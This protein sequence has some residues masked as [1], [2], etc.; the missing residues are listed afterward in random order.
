MIKNSFNI[1]NLTKN[2]AISAIMIA[3]SFILNRYASITTTWFRLGFASTPIVLTSLL[4]GPI[5]G[6]LVGASADLISAF[7][8][9]Q[10][11]Y[12][13]GY[14][15][16]NTLIGVLPYFTSMLIKG[17]KI[18]SST[19][20][21]SLV[22]VICLISVIFVSKYETFKKIELS[23]YI[24]ILIPFFFAL[25]YILLFF[26]YNLFLVKVDKFKPS[27]RDDITY[28]LSDI[29]II[30]LVNHVFISL[31]LLPTWNYIVLGLDF[32]ITSFS[33]AFFHLI[34]S[35]IKSTLLYFLINPI[36]KIYS[37]RH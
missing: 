28:S 21:F 18:A 29:Y 31:M 14:T 37:I 25:Y 13:I 27:S 15:I 4:L 5:W 36:L 32:I 1:R 26:I 10:G 24:R 6:G 20:Y 35:L 30:G 7:L 8:V 9:P 19:L 3:L 23:L 34:S 33:Q 16:D 17:R 22:L 12:F 2:I 11:A